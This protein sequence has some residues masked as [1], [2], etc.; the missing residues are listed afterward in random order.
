MKLTLTKVAP[1]PKTSNCFHIKVEY[2][3]GDADQDTTETVIGQDKTQEQ[4]IDFIET[5]QRAADIVDS[6]RSGDD[7]AYER[8]GEGGNE[9]DSLLVHGMHVSLE[10]DIF[11]EGVSNYFADMRIASII[12]FDAD[13]VKFNV[14]WEENE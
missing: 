8:L 2:S 14:T 9:D 10:H 13:G 4:I 6:I 11:A 5:F 7:S 3:H 12:Y 1:K